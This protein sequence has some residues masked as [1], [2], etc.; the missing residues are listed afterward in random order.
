MASSQPIDINALVDER[1][2]LLD[3]LYVSVKP[4]TARV[5]SLARAASGDFEKIVD[6]AALC[7]PSVP[8]ERLLDLTPKQLTAIID[9]A[10]ASVQEVEAANP[11]GEAPATTVAVPSPSSPA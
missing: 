10:S 1:T 4:V 5:I 11:N 2:I 8:R 7:V 9:V 6:A 3:G